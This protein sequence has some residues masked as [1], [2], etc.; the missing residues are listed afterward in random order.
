V[1]IDA[2]YD[3]AR[4]RQGKL[5]WYARW[6]ALGV[7]VGLLPLAL[8]A[9]SLAGAEVVEAGSTN[10]ELQRGLFRTLKTE[11]VEVSK[12][13][14]ATVRGRAV[15]LPVSGGGIELATAVGSVQH[16]GGFKL[17]AGKRVVRL[18]ELGLDTK[19]RG[20]F[21]KLD[22]K[23]MR[24]ASVPSFEFARAG[25]GDEIEVKRLR[26]NQTTAAALNR[27]LDIER[28]FRP[29]SAFA[30]V[31]SSF[32]PEAVRMTSG[33]MQFSLDPST[34]AK[35]KTLEVDAV[36][37]E[38]AVLGSSPP[39]FGAPLIQGQIY[40]GQNRSWGFLEGGIRIAKLGT[41]EPPESPGPIITFPVLTFINLGLSLES[42]KLTG[43]IHAHD[44]TGGFA[45]GPTGSLAALDLS[46][47][48]VQIDPAA[49]TLSIANVRATLEAAVAHLINETFATPKG[50]APV[51]AA[52]DPLGTFSLTMQAG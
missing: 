2:P 21:A 37:F 46:G 6:A 18:S 31:S 23:R 22:G 5:T 50:K 32:Q 12:L 38:T 34:V 11:G 43:F 9:P 49:R 36:Q 10:L 14:P 29:D 26:L 42:Q 19:Q 7:A 17:R 15:T 44:A 1:D 41:P 20:L 27:K 45:P 25:F 16:A 30:A 8:I 51:L 35:L 48:T 33:S 4:M 13:G 3:F 47:A 40:P 52:G 39:A 28:V 24:I